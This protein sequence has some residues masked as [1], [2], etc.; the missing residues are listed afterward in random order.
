[1][2]ERTAGEEVS[3]LL[4][5]SA[6]PSIIADIES[7]LE[8]E[9]VKKETYEVAKNLV[10]KLMEWNE[11]RNLDAI[12]KISASYNVDDNDV[13]FSL[14]KYSFFLH[15]DNE[16]QQI[17]TMKISFDEKFVSK[18]DVKKEYTYLDETFFSDLY[19]ILS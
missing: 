16:T 7:L 15:L 3:F 11:T 8:V 13:D 6:L 12:F 17:T 2:S 18:I 5:E 1:M 4:K 19:D 14:L 10:M 9:E